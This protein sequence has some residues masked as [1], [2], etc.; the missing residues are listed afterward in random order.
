MLFTKLLLVSLFVLPTVSMSNTFSEGYRVGQLTKFSV[1]GMFIKSGEGQM[2]MGR[3][4]TPYVTTSTDLDGNVT[5]KTINPWYFSANKKHIGKLQ[6]LSGQYVVIK[7]HQQHVRN[8][9]ATNTDYLVQEVYP[10]IREPLS[11]QSIKAKNKAQGTYSKGTRV[12]RIVKLSKKG[13]FV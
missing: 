8:P 2:L 4:S 6:N 10:V 1:K 7:Y 9:L 11:K 3:E 12:G 13:A 5:N